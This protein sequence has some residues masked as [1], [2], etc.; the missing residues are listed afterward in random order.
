MDREDDDRRH[1]IRV[2]ISAAI[3]EAMPAMSYGAAQQLAAAILARLESDGH[4]DSSGRP[5]QPAA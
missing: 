4:L 1:A 5:R 3:R 2:S